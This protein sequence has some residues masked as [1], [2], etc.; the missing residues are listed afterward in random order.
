MVTQILGSIKFLGGISYTSIENIHLEDLI[1]WLTIN[2]PSIIIQ[3][4][5]RST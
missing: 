2:S 4:E 3:T 5:E 1:L